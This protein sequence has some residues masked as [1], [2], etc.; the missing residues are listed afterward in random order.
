MKDMSRV[1]GRAIAAGA[2]IAV[3]AYAAYIAVTWVNYGRPRR[4]RP[5]GTLDQFLGEPEVT[6]HHEIRVRAPHPFTFAAACGADL[7]ES[8]VAR[9]LFKT[10]EFFLGSVSV[11]GPRLRGILAQMRA[12]GWGILSETPDREV[13]LGAITQPWVARPIFHALPPDEFAAFQEPGWVKIAWNLQADPVGGDES[14][15]ITETR[16]AATDAVARRKFRRYWSFIS[17]GVWLIRR[18]LLGPVKREAEFRYS[19]SLERPE[20]G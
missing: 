5:R 17:P 3:G 2:G 4:H 10:R 16:A 6:E 7:Q 11:D 8:Q 19:N 15:F 18:L 20:S 12:L 14:V 13:V 1:L 9:C